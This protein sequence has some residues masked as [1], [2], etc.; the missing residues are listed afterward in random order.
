MEA[1][2]DIWDVGI[3]RA[4]NAGQGISYVNDETGEPRLL[5]QDAK[6]IFGLF[7]GQD[8]F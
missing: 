6:A 8:S 1:A 7:L 3:R 2:V 4:L 5:L